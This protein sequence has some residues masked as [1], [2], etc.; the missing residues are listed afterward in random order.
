MSSSVSLLSSSPLAP[1]RASVITRAT[2]IH[3]LMSENKSFFMILFSKAMTRNN[4]N[5]KNMMKNAWARMMDNIRLE[6]RKDK[7]NKMRQVHE[8][9]MKNLEVAS[10]MRSDREIRSIMEWMSHAKIF[11]ADIPQSMLRTLCSGMENKAMVKNEVLFLQGDPGDRFYII[12]EGEIQLAIQDNPEEEVRLRLRRDEDPEAFKN[13]DWSV[14]G[15]GIGKFLKVLPSGIA[16]GELSMM[17]DSQRTTA[18]FCATDS[19]Q[20]CV[21]DKDLYNHTLR[22]FHKNRASTQAI[23]SKLSEMSTFK[24]W[25]PEVR[26]HLADACTYR[27]FTRGYY[28]TEKGRAIEKMYIVVEG[29]V[30]TLSDT[31]S[32]RKGKKN[33][34]QEED[35]GGTQAHFKRNESESELCRCGPGTVLGDIETFGGISN[36]CLS[37]FVCSAECTVCEVPVETFMGLCKISKHILSSMKDMANQRMVFHKKRYR[38][39]KKKSRRMKK[40]NLL[41]K[42][43]A[44]SARKQAAILEKIEK[45]NDEDI[46]PESPTKPE[47]RLPE[48][49]KMYKSESMPAFGRMRLD[50]LSSM[51]SSAS[52][53]D[54]DDSS[55]GSVG[56]YGSYGSYGTM[57]SIDTVASRFE[58]AAS[59][60]GFLPKLNPLMHANTDPT[61]NRNFGPR[62]GYPYHSIIQPSHIIPSS[63]YSGSPLTLNSSGVRTDRSIRGAMLSEQRKRG[64]R[65]RKGVSMIPVK[66]TSKVKF[67]F[68]GH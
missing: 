15:S 66:G 24:S 2:K 64:V 21:V 4:E 40:A 29:I 42:I 45:F 14:F 67:N 55:I 27:R 23:Y 65:A 6:K 5:K 47:R 59:S 52:V 20:L 58:G 51:M 53:T 54:A 39:E 36:Y 48:I 32:F 41:T 61:F 7:L 9:S 22:N 38:E 10:N 31:R 25:I 19:A 33:R 18:A 50:S 63:S 8:Q 43:A 37:N 56:S 44:P 13:T 35:I 12:I 46:T 57:D 30:A 11:P 34:R 68:S 1:R 49:V 16:F 28:V 60:T 17:D 62:N 3:V 26:Q